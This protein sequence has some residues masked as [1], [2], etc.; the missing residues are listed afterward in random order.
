MVSTLIFVTQIYKLIFV[1]N[2]VLKNVFNLMFS[3]SINEVGRS[4]NSH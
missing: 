2:W 1:K 3:I 4:V